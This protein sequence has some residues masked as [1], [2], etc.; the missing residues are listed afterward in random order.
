MIHEGVPVALKTLHA[1]I[2]AGLEFIHG[3]HLVPFDERGELAEVIAGSADGI[4]DLQIG[5][6]GGVAV[7]A[8]G[9]VAHGAGHIAFGAVRRLEGCA[10]VGIGIRASAHHVKVKIATGSID[11]DVGGMQVVH[12]GIGRALGI[13]AV[14][15]GPD[16][17]AIPL[18]TAAAMVGGGAADAKIEQ[19][20]LAGIGGTDI[21]N[22]Q[23]LPKRIVGAGGMSVD[24][25]VE[26][27][28]ECG[29]GL[30]GAVGIIG[31][32]IIRGIRIV[33]VGNGKRGGGRRADGTGGN[34]LD[35][36]I[37]G[38]DIFGG[39][40]IEN[41]DRKRARSDSGRK[42]NRIG[43]GGVV[44]A[45]GGGSGGGGAKHRDGPAR[46]AG[47]KERNRGGSSAFDDGISR[48]GKGK[49]AG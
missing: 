32:G 20:H 28:L 46:T 12:V 26:G 23:I 19:Q 41:G 29:A 13:N 2:A 24:D 30:E 7:I 15:I 14:G 49:R 10:V 35:L 17:F 9:H 36:Q 18:P 48:G 43:I 25:V 4:D 39:G 8:D 42:R 27:G 45:W 3:I 5:F 6:R 44:T 21:R 31:V 16:V 38:F 47:T 33:I 1:G 37:D 11:A 22:G 40:I 34:G